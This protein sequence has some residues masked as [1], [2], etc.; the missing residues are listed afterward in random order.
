MSSES[1]ESRSSRHAESR[2]VLTAAARRRFAMLREAGLLGA[3][4]ES[5]REFWARAN[6]KRKY[7]GRS[8][9]DMLEGVLARELEAQSPEIHRRVMAALET[10]LPA[11]IA[12]RIT[13][14]RIRRGVLTIGVSHPVAA[15]NIRRQFAGQIERMLQR[16]AADLKV[17]EV[18]AR[19]ES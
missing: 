7:T 1:G 2:P 14:T 13:A 4:L 6:R 8:V 10:I 16:D 5:Q 19:V 15:F 3:S 18:R 9:S 17:L 11:P 12:A